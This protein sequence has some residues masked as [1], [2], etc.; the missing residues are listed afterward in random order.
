MS[1][2]SSLNCCGIPSSQSCGQ[3]VVNT[4]GDIILECGDYILQ[5]V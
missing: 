1:G 5:E 3:T 4:D 2:I